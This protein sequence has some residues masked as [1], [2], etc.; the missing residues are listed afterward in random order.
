[1]L[2]PVQGG[3]AMNGQVPLQLGQCGEIQTTL[4]TNV[5]LSF[6]MFQLMG[7]KLTRVRKTS[8]A[9]IAARGKDKMYEGLE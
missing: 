3:T 7:A 6:L 2:S 4:H 9:H 5:L 1:M 8:A